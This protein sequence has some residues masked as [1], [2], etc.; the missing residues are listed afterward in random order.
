MDPVI[1]H[2][3]VLPVDIDNCK[4]VIPFVNGKIARCKITK[5]SHAVSGGYLSVHVAL[6]VLTGLMVMALHG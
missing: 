3:K 2:M 4:A 6:S 5:A 1:A